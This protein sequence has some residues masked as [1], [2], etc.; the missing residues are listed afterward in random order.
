MLVL[1]QVVLSFQLP[2]AIWPLVRFT[3]DRTLMGAFANGPVTK[4]VAW[5]LFGGI[6][7]AN[8]WL[9]ALALTGAG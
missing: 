5:M 2:F 3:S 1:S 7:A 6:S 9:V 4:G 8:L